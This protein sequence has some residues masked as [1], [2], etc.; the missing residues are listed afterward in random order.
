MK[1][2]TDLEVIKELAEKRA[3]ENWD[4]RSFLKGYPMDMDE[5]DEIVHDFYEQ[6]VKEIDCKECGN[7]CR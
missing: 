2:E 5:M 1:I 3:D 4:F 6:L 7:C